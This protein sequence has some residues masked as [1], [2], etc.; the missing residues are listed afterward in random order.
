M[1]RFLYF[2]SKLYSSYIT[3]VRMNETALW[4]IIIF[5]YVTPECFIFCIFIVIYE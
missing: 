3:T 4:I 1:T 5:T 2:L